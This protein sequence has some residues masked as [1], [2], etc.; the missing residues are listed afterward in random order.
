[1]LIELTE[2]EEAV[3]KTVRSLYCSLD[4]I[5]TELTIEC[6]AL[7]SSL[8]KSKDGGQ[9]FQ[10]CK[11]FFM[12][13]KK[14]ILTNVKLRSSDF[15]PFFQSALKYRSRLKEKC[16]TQTKADAQAFLPS[17]DQK[18]RKCMYAGVVFKSELKYLA[19]LS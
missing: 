3:L 13:I 12:N 6:P 17:A 14:T 9:F 5:V 15:L 1:M 16:I 8:W 11:L 18:K 4:A 7:P 10:C 19:S 2:W